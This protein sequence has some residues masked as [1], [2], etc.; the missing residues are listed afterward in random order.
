MPSSGELPVLTR[1]VPI[2]LQLEQEHLQTLPDITQRLAPADRD[3][4]CTS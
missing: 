1:D 4:A 2:Y 3:V